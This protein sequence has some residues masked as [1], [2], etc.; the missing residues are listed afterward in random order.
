MATS[1]LQFAMT[2]LASPVQLPLPPTQSGCAAADVV[3][4]Y[5]SGSSKTFS[6]LLT[7]ITQSPAFV[8]RKA[9]P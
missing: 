3:S 9:A 4:K 8:V 2:E 6:G 5:Q 7:A 1:M